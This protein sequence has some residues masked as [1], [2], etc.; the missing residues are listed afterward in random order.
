MKLI[1]LFIL[2]LAALA[3][4]IFFDKKPEQK[5]KQKQSVQELMNVVTINRNGIVITR[6]Q[7]YIGFLE[8]SGRKTDLLSEREQQGLIDLQTA[9][10]STMQEAWQI[11][12]VS[13]PEDNSA[14][15]N[16]YVEE[17]EQTDSPVKK[18]MLRE[19]I[20]WQNKMLLSGENRQRQF[21]IKLW[22]KQRDGAEAELAG[23]MNQMQR[24]FEIAGFACEQAGREEVIRLCNMIHNPSALLYEQ[25]DV[26][27][28]IPE[29]GGNL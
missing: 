26:D 28:G 21:Y 29:I 24:S 9:E 23:R 22:E 8:V 12:A 25:A 15:V 16:Q 13:Q 18:K 2:A 1:I 7:Y 4:F 3:Y 6:D 27:Y 14:I 20:A 5:K 11:L 19:A 17:L 10:V